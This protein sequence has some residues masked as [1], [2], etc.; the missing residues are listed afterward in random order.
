MV[1]VFQRQGLKVLPITKEIFVPD[2][3][4]RSETLLSLGKKKGLH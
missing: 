3:F 1:V 2:F 4:E